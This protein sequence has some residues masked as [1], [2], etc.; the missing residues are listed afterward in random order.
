MRKMRRRPR[1]G[2]ARAVA[3]GLAWYRPE[4]WARLIE[5]SADA[6]NLE[7]T[8]EKWEVIAEKAVAD[9][10]QEGVAVQRVDVDVE[11]LVEW[12]LARQ[13]PVN[14]QARSSFAAHKLE[15]Q[16]RAMG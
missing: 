1:H 7:S 15:E 8:H 4:Q 9:F 6:G 16:S 3:M 10:A 11:E 12:C 14:A 2:N 5:V 13:C